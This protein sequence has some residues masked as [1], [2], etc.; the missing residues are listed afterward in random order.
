MPAIAAKGS[1]D[2]NQ[3]SMSFELTIH[4][5]PVMHVS[6]EKIADALRTY[7][8]WLV[9]LTRRKMAA[10]GPENKPQERLN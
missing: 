7:A 5:D 4:V 1:L 10:S 8:T 6:S 2:K 9:R 3:D